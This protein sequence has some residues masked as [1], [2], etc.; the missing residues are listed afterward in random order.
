MIPGVDPGCRDGISPPPVGSKP[1]GPTSA[2]LRGAGGRLQVLAESRHA[3]GVLPSRHVGPV[4]RC[5]FDVRTS[6]ERPSPG[7]HPFGT[8]PAKGAHKRRGGVFTEKV[9]CN[10]L[11]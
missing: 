1:T 8:R 7:M 11:T 5:K 6:V 9:H 10:L 2:R 3:A 4:S